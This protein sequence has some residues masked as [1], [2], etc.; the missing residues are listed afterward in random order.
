[1]RATL[2]M[3][4]ALV[5]A[6][7]TDASAQTVTRPTRPYRGLFG[8]GPAPDPNRTRTELTLTGNALVG[9][10]TWLSPDGA[11]VPDNPF[12]ARQ[13]GRA[14]TGE[15]A[16]AYFRGRAN[17]SLAIDGRARTNSYS[18]TGV[19]PTIGGNVVVTADT[20]LGRVSQLHATQSLAYEPTL[21]LGG[22]LPRSGDRSVPVAPELAVST[23]YLEQRSWSSNSSVGFSRRWTPR[24]TLQIDS[25]YSRSTYLDEF[26]YNTR[27]RLAG[28][29]HS[30]Q[31]SRT[32]SV[33]GHYSFSDL[34]SDAAGAPT[35][36]MT[37]Q[38][39]DGSFGYTRRLSPTR[40]L[41]LNIGVGATHVSTLRALDR[42]ALVYWT[43]SADGSLSWDVGRSW[44]IAANYTR[45]VS[46]LEGVSLTAFATD[47]AR[48]SVSGLINSRMETSL[49]AT[50]SNGRSGGLGTT[51]R[52]ENYN[53]S[54]QV[55][56]AISRCCATAVNYDYYFYD[57]QNVV[58]LP[59]GFSP[60]FDRQAI[61]VGFTVWLPLYG[62]YSN[63][64]R[65]RGARGN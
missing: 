3:I 19:D 38:S 20:N 55:R 46:V 49:S 8:G 39:V 43:P 24:H 32:S 35:T 17:R 18:G 48:A 41:S 33:R 13:S 7:A 4:A 56:Y 54:L 36:P 65:S 61:R 60:S 5:C 58:D 45:A 50:Y 42:S 23:G 16:L 37:N 34:K 53:G 14:V 10:D 26:G 59:S 63:G 40:Q 27:S 1:M 11:A 64:E 2:A 15:A 29:S 31:F 47:S 25:A 44:A 12:D 52:F 51:G 57:F 22:Q 9:Y 6:V 30:W 21:V 62:T 28:L